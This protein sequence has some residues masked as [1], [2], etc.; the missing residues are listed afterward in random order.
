MSKHNNIWVSTAVLCWAVKEVISH[1]CT[2]YI[3]LSVNICDPFYLHTFTLLCFQFYIEVLYVSPIILHMIIITSSPN[4]LKQQESKG[5]A[6]KLW[7]LVNDKK[8]GFT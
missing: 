7:E 3:F 1:S 4:S 2:T 5:K 6:Y 8:D